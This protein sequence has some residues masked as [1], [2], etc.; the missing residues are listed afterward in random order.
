MLLKVL[1]P[2]RFTI[3]Y[4]H[5][6]AT[7]FA[8]KDLAASCLTVNKT[9]KEVARQSK[10]LTSN[11]LNVNPCFIFTNCNLARGNRVKHGE[12]LHKFINTLSSKSFEI[13]KKNLSPS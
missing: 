11:S 12:N 5:H 2:S 1:K 4:R 10:N 8:S 3:S 6:M 9:L 13:P 7:C